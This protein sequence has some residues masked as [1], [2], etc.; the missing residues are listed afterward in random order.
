MANSDNCRLIYEFFLLKRIYDRVVLNVRL[1]DDT[2]EEHI[3]CHCW[4]FE[5]HTGHMK[6]RKKNYY[7]QE[8]FAI[9]RRDKHGKLLG[10][11]EQSIAM[12]W[13]PEYVRIWPKNTFPK[14]YLTDK[15]KMDRWVDCS[16]YFI[17]R[18]NSNKSPVHIELAELTPKTLKFDF[19][20]K[21]FITK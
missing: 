1:E 18:V 16:D 14:P 9:F 4:G 6:N 20:N 21:R 8:F 19:R 2:I 11:C 17:V 10:Y 7:N 12:C 13:S 15:K 5:T 3:E